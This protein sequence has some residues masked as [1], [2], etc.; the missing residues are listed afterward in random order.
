MRGAALTIAASPSSRPLM[1]S[2]YPRSVR[3]DSAHGRHA[4]Q[5]ARGALGVGAFDLDDLVAD[6][7]MSAAGAIGG[8]DL[9]ARQHDDAVAA[10]RLPRGSASKRES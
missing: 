9:A 4:L 7:A 2:R 3:T 6:R 5:R 8:H 10:I 1:P